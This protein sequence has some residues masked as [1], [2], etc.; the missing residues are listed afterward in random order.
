MLFKLFFCR[1]TTGEKTEIEDLY[2]ILF[3]PRFGTVLKL[4]TKLEVDPLAKRFEHA[5]E[6]VDTPEPVVEK[7]DSFHEVI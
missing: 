1:K 3:Y 4:I 5:I 2:I 7:D 6:R